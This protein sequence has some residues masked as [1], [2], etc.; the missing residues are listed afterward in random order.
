MKN[1]LRLGVIGVGAVVREIYQHLY[2]SSAYT[3]I[4]NITAVADPNEQYRNWFSDLAGVPADRRFASYKDM[5]AKVELDAVQVNTPDH[6]HCGPT[7]DALKA[8]LD[9]VVPKPTA[10]TV[11]DAHAMIQTAKST[12]RFLGI[13]FHKREDPRIK[14]AEARYQN[15][16]YGNLQVAVFYMLDKLMV[17]D[18]NHSP[19]FFASPDFAEKNT[20]ISFLTVHMADALMKIV[21]LVPVQVRAT[22]YS[23]KLPSLKPIAVK[24]DDTV[25]TEILF[26]SGATAHI[27]TGWAL[28]NTAWSTTVQ[29]SR[30]ICSE[31]LIDLGLD[32]PGLREIHPE[33]I[34]EINPLFRN[35]E[36]DKS[37]TGYGVSS[38]G[39]LYQQILAFRNGKLAAKDL[40][41]ALSPVS[42]GFYTT[43]VLQAAEKSLVDGKKLSS[44]VTLGSPI[45]L[46]QM[47]AQ[48][49]GADA[50]KEYGYA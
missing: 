36:K 4:L 40:E 13:D 31:G 41:A 38:P 28:P 15:G 11:K 49:L 1:Q 50:V 9:V 7:V 3:P 37:V 30:M 19:R 23:Q 44:G 18:P 47:L 10:A 48:E 27:I 26:D 39:R 42:L 17:A 46:K 2:F 22:G 25:D 6:L 34:F 14:E 5:L 35:F 24:G 45:D 12:G 8:G 20:P 16:R 32:T 33:G 21:N 43:L 29:S